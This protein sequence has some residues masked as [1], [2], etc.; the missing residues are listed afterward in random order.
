M[1]LGLFECEGSNETEKLN[2][3]VIM[4]SIFQILKLVKREPRRLVRN[5]IKRE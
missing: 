3:F 4:K 1:I 5:L 2:L